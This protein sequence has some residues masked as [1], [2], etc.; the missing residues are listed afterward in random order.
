MHV[1]YSALHIGRKTA[2]ESATGG[3][4]YKMYL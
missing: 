4:P 1:I 2:K 3:T